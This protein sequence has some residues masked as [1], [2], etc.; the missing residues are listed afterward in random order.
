MDGTSGR[1]QPIIGAGSIFGKTRR[2]GYS[3]VELQS[4]RNRRIVDVADA[5]AAGHRR[6][7]PDV[8]DEIHVFVDLEGKA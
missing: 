7:V 1:N 6:H 4:D 3:E 8:R 5:V 2:R